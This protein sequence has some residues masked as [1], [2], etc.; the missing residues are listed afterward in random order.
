[1]H[2]PCPFC[3]YQ[4]IKYQDN[5]S[6]ECYFHIRE[7]LSISQFEVDEAWNKRVEQPRQYSLWLIFLI[8]ALVVTI[9]ELISLIGL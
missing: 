1:M 4:Q 5:H 6:E 2:K 7:L 8:T 3:S 9:V